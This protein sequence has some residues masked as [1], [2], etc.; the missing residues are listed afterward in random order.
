MLDCC[1][2]GLTSHVLQARQSDSPG[3]RTV[4]KLPS[5]CE[6]RN[7]LTAEVRFSNLLELSPSSSLSSGNVGAYGEELPPDTLHS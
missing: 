2:Y 7:S 6:R 4:A 3:Q 1:A 5:L